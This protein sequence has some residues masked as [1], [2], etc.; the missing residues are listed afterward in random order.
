MARIT[1]NQPAHLTGHVGPVRF[2]DGHAETEDAEALAYFA[3][4]PERFTVETPE[5][6]A[7]EVTD[8]PAEQPPADPN[9]K[10]RPPRGK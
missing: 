9:P 2:V 6:P 3:S 7:D 5:A 1:C 8:T 4:D 10:P